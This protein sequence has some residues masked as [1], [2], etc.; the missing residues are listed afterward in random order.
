MTGRTIN[1]RVNALANKRLPW[2]LLV[3]V[4]F[5]FKCGMIVL[6]KI[7]VALF[8]KPPMKGYVIT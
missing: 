1:K 8:T 6:Q 2:Y 7:K 4:L 5:R 3:L